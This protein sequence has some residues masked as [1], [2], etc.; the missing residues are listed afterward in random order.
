V[1]C[2]SPS[3]CVALSDRG[4]I[5]TSSAPASGHAWTA[6]RPI[7][8]QSIGASALACPSPSM[9]V[10]VQGRNIAVSRHPGGGVRAWPVTSIPGRGAFT[11]VACPAVSMCVAVD[12]AGDVVSSTHPAGGTGAWEVAGVAI[13][14]G[15]A[16]SVS[17]PSVA[18]CV[19]G[20]PGKVLWSRNP[21]A[22]APRWRAAAPGA[23]GA[24]A[25]SLPSVSCASPALCVAVGD[26]GLIAAA[27]RPSGG[28]RAWHDVQLGATNELLGI[29]CTP[30]S[31]CVAVD[32]TG[33]AITSTRPTDPASWRAVLLRGCAWRSTAREAC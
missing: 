26:P 5:V 29:S 33:H 18:L 25:S 10:A 16:A 7:F 1:S 12:D 28:G 20:G 21:L 13:A 2:P 6:P 22:R 19:A 11:G 17:C 31:L 30:S 32:G 4:D 14:V 9:C 8:G 24:R 3:F 15:R 27:T 23:A